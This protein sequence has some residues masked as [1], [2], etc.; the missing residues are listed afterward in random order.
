M[1]FLAEVVFRVEADS[2]FAV[3]SL[4]EP[5]C[6]SL[7]CDTFGSTVLIGA[8]I[9]L[10]FCISCV[11]YNNLSYFVAERT[12]D[13]P[14]GLRVRTYTCCNVLRCSLRRSAPVRRILIQA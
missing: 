5:P 7:S 3:S 10:L 14:H 12:P 13:L 1:Q 8:A 4:P 2:Q 6:E 11:V 9:L